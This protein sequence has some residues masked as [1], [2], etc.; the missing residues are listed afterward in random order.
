MGVR[1]RWTAT[2]LLVLAAQAALVLWLELALGLNGFVRQALLGSA[3]IAVSALGALI[4][5]ELGSSLGVLVTFLGFGWFFQHL[6][7]PALSGSPGAGVSTLGGALVAPIYFAVRRVF[8]S[9]RRG[10][11]PLGSPEA[12]T[13]R[14]R[15]AKTLESIAPASTA[16][17][18]SL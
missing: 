13:V 7:L 3:S 17:Q 6:V 2:A 10:D 16:V 4:P 12:P 5:A 15:M 1:R 14:A 8:L 9:P 18:E 11:R